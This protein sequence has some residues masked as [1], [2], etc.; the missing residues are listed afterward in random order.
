MPIIRREIHEQETSP[1]GNIIDRTI[2]EYEYFEEE[3][4]YIYNSDDSEEEEIEEEIEEE[5]IEEC[6]GTTCENKECCPN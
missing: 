2:Y 6:A 5:E 1:E 4:D 3:I